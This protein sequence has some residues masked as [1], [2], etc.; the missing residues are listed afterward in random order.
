MT[1]AEALALELSIPVQI[2]K[3]HLDGASV[4][5]KA[6]VVDIETL[7]PQLNAGDAI[8][9]LRIENLTKDLGTWQRSYKRFDHESCHTVGSARNVRARMPMTIS[10]ARRASMFP[11]ARSR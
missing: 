11:A 8:T 3:T 5:W 7:V 10:S 1:A 2:E 9:P 6:I 4:G